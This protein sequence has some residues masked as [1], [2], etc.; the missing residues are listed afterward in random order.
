MQNALGSR[1]FLSHETLKIKIGKAWHLG[2]PPKPDLFDFL[3]CQAAAVG[4]A[5]NLRN[6][7]KLQM[8]DD[9]WDLT[10]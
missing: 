4:S 7:E 8:S 2:L 3:Q 5:Q 6:W 1:D 9:I 10:T